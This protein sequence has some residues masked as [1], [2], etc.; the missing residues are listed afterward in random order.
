MAIFV[1]TNL[2]FYYN[3][4]NNTFQVGQID[5]QPAEIVADELFR[6]FSLSNI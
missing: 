3:W 4:S 1:E 2:L 5:D 6:L